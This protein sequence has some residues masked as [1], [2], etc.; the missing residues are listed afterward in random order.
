MTAN[1]LG[2]AESDLQTAFRYYE[3]ARR[4]LG[5]EIARYLSVNCSLI[6]HFVRGV[7]G[8]EGSFQP[9]TTDR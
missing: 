9:C 4:G 6:N 3:L 7:A 1:I 8:T 5:V 2:D